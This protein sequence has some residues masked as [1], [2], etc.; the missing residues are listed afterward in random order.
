MH[1]LTQ[2]SIWSGV[3]LTPMPQ[4]SSKAA[5]LTGKTGWDFIY[6]TAAKRKKTDNILSKLDVMYNTQ[7]TN[8]SLML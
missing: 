6:S 7:G 4:L 2:S 3:I 1:V 8:L 5:T